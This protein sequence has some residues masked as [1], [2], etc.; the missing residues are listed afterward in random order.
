L[1]TPKIEPILSLSEPEANNTEVLQTEIKSTIIP[2][3]LVSRSSSDASDGELV[4]NEIIGT[5]SNLEKSFLE[6]PADRSESGFLMDF[7]DNYIDQVSTESSP[8]ASFSSINEPSIAITPLPT[9]SSVPTPVNINEGKED[10]KSHDEETSRTDYVVVTDSPLTSPSS[11]PTPIVPASPRR[12]VSI[13]GLWSSNKESIP[14]ANT[15]TTTVIPDEITKVENNPSTSIEQNI[16]KETSKMKEE[17]DDE[18]VIIDD[19]L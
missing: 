3:S 2:I 19:S 12:R 15:T 17:E 14:N 6:D 7:V 18:F 13:F 1:E 11:T 16:T 10:I 9:L 5:I 8:S 4:E